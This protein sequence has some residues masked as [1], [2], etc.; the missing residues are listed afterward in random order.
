MV[1]CAMPRQ[2]YSLVKYGWI[3]VFVEENKAFFDIRIPDCSYISKIS[4]LDCLHNW[5]FSTRNRSYHVPVQ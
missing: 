3:N 5:P 2:Y 4:T 1:L